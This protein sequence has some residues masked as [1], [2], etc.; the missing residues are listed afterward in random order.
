MKTRS[1]TSGFKIRSIGVLVRCRVEKCLGPH[2]VDALR[3]LELLGF[4]GEELRF[5]PACL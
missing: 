1:R 2:S 3:G 5:L 4:G